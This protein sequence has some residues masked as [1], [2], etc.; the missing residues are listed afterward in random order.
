MNCAASGGPRGWHHGPFGSIWDVAGAD[1]A[2][3]CTILAAGTGRVCDTN[4]GVPR[5]GLLSWQSGCCNSNQAKEQRMS[6]PSLRELEE[7][8][9]RLY[10]LLAA[11]GDFRRGSVTQNYRRGGKPTC[12]C[13]QPGHPGH[14]P[15]YL[16]T[17][18]VPGSR[19]RGRQ[20]APGEMEKVRRG[21][22]GH[23]QFSPLAPP[24]VGVNE[25]R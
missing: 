5:I 17:R 2:S 14:G 10:A 23:P 9:D 22:G 18:S 21:P 13:A 25:G 12:A 4:V 1:Q 15:R 24:N 16:W 7:Q 3:S 8:R 6:E 20:L 11:T 19:T